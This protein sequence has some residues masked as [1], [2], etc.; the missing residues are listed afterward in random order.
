MTS[1][2]SSDWSSD[3]EDLES[4]LKISIPSGRRASKN[5]SSGTHKKLLFVINHVDWFWSHRYALAR[6]AQ[7]EGYV[8]YVAMARKAD[9]LAGQ[10]EEDN[11]LLEEGFMPVPL[12]QY[13]SAI[14]SILGIGRILARH[15]R[16]IDPDIVHAI[17]IKYSFI[18]SLALA[19]SCLGR[20][21]R[22]TA[23]KALFTLAGLG[24]LFSG[25]DKKAAILRFLGGPFLRWAFARR[26]IHLIFQN[27]DDFKIMTGRGLA[28]PN[29]ARVIIGSGVDTEK[30]IAYPESDSKI[31]RIVMPTR[32]VKEKGVAIFVEAATI[33]A[34]G[35]CEAEFVLAGGLDYYNPSAYK[36]SEIEELLA[37]TPVQ[38]L[39]QV[40]DMVAFYASA[41]LVVYPSYYR[42]GVPKVL[43]EAAASGRAI[44]TTDHPGCREVVQNAENG[45][46]VPVKDAHATAQAIQKLLDAPQKRYAMGERSRRRAETEFDISYIN[47][48]TLDVYKSL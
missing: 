15:I 25:E 44:I 34:E 2:Q 24:Y 6:A 11:R 1:S 19:L 12:P 39:G 18:T 20:N 27:P 3:G 40:D 41:T 10:A 43:L 48:Q 26:G 42:E 4:S 22:R 16:Q 5:I 38:W 31:P 9:D 35:G 29:N 21:A 7:K 30:F 17:T 33:L 37:K 46:L 23:P 28:R 45:Y 32:L 13:H 14:R 8:V 36:K 47:S